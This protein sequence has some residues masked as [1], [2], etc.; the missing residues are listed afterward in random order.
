MATLYEPVRVDVLFY[1]RISTLD[2]LRELET[3]IFSQFLGIDPNAI[4]RQLLRSHRDESMTSI[5]FTAFDDNEYHMWRHVLLSRM[6]TI[7]RMH[8]GFYVDVMKSADFKS[9]YPDRKVTLSPHVAAYIA[10][11]YP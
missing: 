8:L 1:G 5:G 11:N 2:H 3:R 9:H 4:T 10:I 6:H 7:K